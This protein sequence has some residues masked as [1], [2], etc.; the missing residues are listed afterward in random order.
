LPAE[1]I[2][3]L[4]E[5]KAWRAEIDTSRTEKISPLTEKIARR[6]EQKARLMDFRSRFATVPTSEA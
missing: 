4:I 5:Q 3:R 2:A 1:K 6:A